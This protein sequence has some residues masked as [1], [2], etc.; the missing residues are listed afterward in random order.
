MAPGRGCD[1]A[2][3]RMGTNNNNRSLEGHAERRDE[4]WGEERDAQK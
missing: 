1:W 3:L 4:R 2:V